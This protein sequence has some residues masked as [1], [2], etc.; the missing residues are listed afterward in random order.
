MGEKDA[1]HFHLFVYGTLKSG[2]R[3]SAEQLRGCRKVA[4]ATVAGTLY[5]IDGQ[6]PALMLYGDTVVEGE[7]WLCPV[8]RLEALDRYEGVASGLFRRVGHEV[9]AD[10]A[11]YACWLYVAGPR[12][13]PKLTAANRRPLAPGHAAPA[14]RGD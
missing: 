7:V 9:T 14:Q 8:D 6:Y 5:D 1:E 2:A 3:A 4:D 11:R 13:A 12:L 10:E